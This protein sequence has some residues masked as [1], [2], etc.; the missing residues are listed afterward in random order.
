[1]TDEHWRGTQLADNSVYVVHVI[2]KRTR[3][4]GLGKTSYR[5]WHSDMTDIP[6]QG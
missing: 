5:R 6:K 2:G 4:E 3:I 1:M